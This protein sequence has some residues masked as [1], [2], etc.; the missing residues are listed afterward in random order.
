[1]GVDGR[2]MAVISGTA[3]RPLAEKIVSELGMDLL[4]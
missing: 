4:Q 3:N 1:M 2:P